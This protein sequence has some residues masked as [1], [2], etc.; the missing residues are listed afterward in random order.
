MIASPARKHA[1][2]AALEKIST[3]CP[4]VPVV[5]PYS[6]TARFE[7]AR[8]SVEHRRFSFSSTAG[9]KRERIPPEIAS[10]HDLAWFSSK[11]RHPS[12]S[13]TLP[14]RCHRAG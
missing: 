2:Q 5:G 3:F 6:L 13:P 1:P 8:L 10:S 4:Q 7:A 14:D 11:A 12:R 9:E